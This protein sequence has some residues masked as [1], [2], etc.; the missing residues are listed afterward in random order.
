[1]HAGRPAV[2]AA[3]AA[4]AASAAAAAGRRA[5]FVPARAAGGRVQAPRHD[6]RPV[7]VAGVRVRVR[8]CV[9][10]CVRVC[11]CACVRV[12]VRVRVRVCTHLCAC[13]SRLARRAPHATLPRC[14][15]PRTAPT[16]PRAPTPHQRGHEHRRRRQAECLTLP[17][18]LD[19]SHLV[20]CAPT[21]GGKSLVGEVLLLRRL[22]ATGKAALL[23]SARRWLL[24]AGAGALVHWLAGWLAGCCR[25]VGWSVGCCAAECC[26]WC[27]AAGW[28]RARVVRGCGA[29][30]PR[31][32]PAPLAAAG[33][34]APFLLPGVRPCF[35]SGGGGV[36]GSRT[37]PLVIDS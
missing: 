19:G 18:V 29:W 2:A 20:Y 23:V 14:A 24:A 4:A 17:G 16:P 30:R 12:R 34:Q 3:A 8:V 28:R 32:R 10:A 6:A 11:V 36:L 1:M 25:A 13:A 5:G 21:S 15:A 7:R 31:P 26:A 37:P 27:V 33:W 22:V 9:C 35:S